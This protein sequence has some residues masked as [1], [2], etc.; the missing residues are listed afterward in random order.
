[1]R[2]KS[3]KPKPL[4]DAKKILKKRIYY[5][6]ET[7]SLVIFLRFGSLNSDE[8]KWPY[9]FISIQ[10]DWH[11]TINSMEYYQLMEKERIHDNESQIVLQQGN[12]EL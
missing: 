8:R 11:Q 10:E 5:S 2:K 12:I 9:S 6:L 3:L 4:I 7:H 1:M